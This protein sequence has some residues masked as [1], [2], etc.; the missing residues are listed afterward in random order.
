METVMTDLDLLAPL[1]SLSRALVG[2]V[3]GASPAVVSVGSHR[4]RSSGFIWRP[5]LVVTADDALADEG[6]IAVDLSNGDTV[7]ARVVGRDPTTD[8]ALLRVDRTDLASARLASPELVIGAAAVVVG[9]D[10]ALPTTAFGVV[11]AVGGPW[12]SMRGGTID[13]RLE[14]A[15]PLVGRAEGGLALDAAGEAFGMVVFGPRRRVLVIPAST[16]E[17]V[18]ALLER[19][20]RIARGYLGL[21]LRP[22]AV[23]GGNG[24][25]AMVISVDPKGP[26]AH[27]GIH[28]GDVIVAWN[29][30]P[31]R[32]MRALLS[33]LGPDSVGRAITIDVRRAGEVRKISLTIGERPAN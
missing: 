6:E 17:R 12:R 18:A 15:V 24:A 16:I 21:G 30:E 28:Q 23:E 11:S 5:G 29:G 10:G 20:G 9:A 14:L 26:G 32:E 7:P 8:V 25:G 19:H 3:A 13:A 22:V 2:V 1:Q 33:A 31:F 27:A 4:S